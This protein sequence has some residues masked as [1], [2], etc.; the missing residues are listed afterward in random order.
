MA[1]ERQ[2]SPPPPSLFRSFSFCLY[3]IRI[4]FFS[5][6]CTSLVFVDSLLP[7]SLNTVHCQQKFSTIRISG[8]KK[9]VIDYEMQH[10]LYWKEKSFKTIKLETYFAF[11]FSRWVSSCHWHSVIMW[12]LFYSRTTC[13]LYTSIVYMS[14]YQFTY[15]VLLCWK[16]KMFNQYF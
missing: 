13:P 3:D 15:L 14:I 12:Y 1:R 4:Y 8:G 11:C 9:I 5:K 2:S 6:H 16:C 10:A 7:L